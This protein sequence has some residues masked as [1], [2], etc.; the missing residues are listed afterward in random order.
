M[1]NLELC[2]RSATQLRGNW[3]GADGSGLALLTLCLLTLCLLILWGVL[4]WSRRHP[5]PRR[6]WLQPK[7]RKRLAVFSV[8]FVLVIAVYDRPLTM[9]LPRDLGTKQQ[10]IVIL[11]RGKPLQA[12][13][14]DSAI[15]LWRAQRAPVIFSSGIW[16][17]PVILRAL[18][19]QGIPSS[20]S[21]GENCSTTT[22]ENAQFSAAI[23]QPQG[24]RK[25]LLVTDGPHMWRSLLEFKAQG[26]TVIPHISPLPALH[27]M[28]YADVV[29]REY[30]F[31]I[32]TSIRAGLAGRRVALQ[33]PALPQ[34]L[35]QA[36]EYGR[37]NPYPQPISPRQNANGSTVAG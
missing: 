34:L 25:I 5:L 31:L 33:R 36:Q 7:I 2:R 8:V 37:T 15:Q 10:A 3:W 23:L 32:S 21:D 14:I 17:T 12:E 13:R 1:F 30:S 18:A 20:A 27:W 22:V 26:F 9:F 4:W 28:S 16:D 35:Q 11:G 29:W 6:W 24:I 19:A